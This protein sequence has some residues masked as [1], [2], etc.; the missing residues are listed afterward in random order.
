MAEFIRMNYN[1]QT[2]CKLNRVRLHQQVIFPS[3]V[4]DASGRAIESKYLEERLW[5]ERWSSL[6]FPKE[7]LSDS[8]FRLWNVA[9]LQIRA[10]GGR[11]HI[12][13]HLRQ[14]HKVWPW[15]YDIESLQLFHIKE[16]GVDLYEPALGEGA[17][18][19]AKC[20][21]CTEERTG[22]VP[23]GGPCTIGKAAG[24]GIFKI[25]SFT[26]NPPP[27]EPPLTFRQVLS[28]WGHIWMWE[29]LNLSGDGE[30][31][32][33]AWL[34]EAI[35]ENTLVAVTDGSYMKELYPDMNS[36]A[37]ILE[38]KRLLRANHGS[39]LLS[40]Q[41]PWSTCY[42]SYS[43]QHQQGQPHPNR[44]SSHILRLPGCTQ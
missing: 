33:S 35:K 37:F 4:M 24:E 14:G 39:L 18:T 36:C 10:L 44:L 13:G 16:D 42:P 2:L 40:R 11:L 6:I 43:P 5:N 31:K 30:D 19:R 32:D 41:T 34:M 20:Y 7:I 12:G 38:C 29:S 27:T 8:N 23:R 25:I 22:V 3:D 21:V 28:K 15:K 26:D 9:L 17:R 1:T